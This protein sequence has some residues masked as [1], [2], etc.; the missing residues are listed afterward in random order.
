MNICGKVSILLTFLLNLPTYECQGIHICPTLGGALEA[1]PSQLQLTISVCLAVRIPIDFPHRGQSVLIF[2]F[3]YIAKRIFSV[4]S[5][6]KHQSRGQVL[7]VS[8]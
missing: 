5:S 8:I 2:P 6:A 3:D 7:P 4:W 1:I